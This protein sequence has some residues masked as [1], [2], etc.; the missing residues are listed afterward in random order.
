MQEETLLSIIQLQHLYITSTTN[1]KNKEYFKALE[2]LEESYTLFD[3]IIEH[4]P[5]T[6]TIRDFVLELRDLIIQDLKQIN[7]Y[8]YDKEEFDVSVCQPTLHEFDLDESDIRLDYED[9]VNYYDQIQLMINLWFP[10]CYKKIKT[11]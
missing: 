1:T 6:S 4:I 7:H 2:Y 10:C 3:D 9:P 8:I 5:P 11:D